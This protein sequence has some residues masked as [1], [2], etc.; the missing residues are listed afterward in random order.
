MY[1]NLLH[2][3]EF[4]R[5]IQVQERPSRPKER[6]LP[7]WHVLASHA[8]NIGSILVNWSAKFEN[9]KFGLGLWA[10]L[11]LAKMLTQ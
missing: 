8:E 10:S 5:Q 11:N 7:S 4:K 1:H 9:F 2:T 3:K 6:R